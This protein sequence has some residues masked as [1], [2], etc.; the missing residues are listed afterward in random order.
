MYS[1]FSVLFFAL[2]TLKSISKPAD[3][4]PLDLHHSGRGTLPW[5]AH[6]LVDVLRHNHVA[7]DGEPVMCSDFVQNPHKHVSGPNGSEK[8][9]APEATA[10]DE[11]QIFVTV[12][13]FEIF[14]HLRTKAPPFPERR[15]GWGTR[16]SIPH[17]DFQQVVSSRG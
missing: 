7:H 17:G 6:Q 11:M 1:S 10:G 12:A 5:L 8:R 3:S 2:Q 4:S 15:E 9:E 16:V 14:G 13:T